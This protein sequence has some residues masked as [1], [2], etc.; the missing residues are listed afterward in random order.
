MTLEEY[1]LLKH[2]IENIKATMLDS[3][4][5]ANTQAVEFHG[6]DVNSFSDAE[7]LRSA[8]NYYVDI[9][10]RAV[11]IPNEPSSY[12]ISIGDI[13]LITINGNGFNRKAVIKLISTLITDQRESGYIT[14]DGTVYPI[15]SI[16]VKSPLGEAILNK[17]VGTTQEY[18]ADYRLFTA[19]IERK[20]SLNDI[21]TKKSPERH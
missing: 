19:T 11:V 12:E 10:S 2:T 5:N 15:Q 18:I 9:L 6:Y 4:R 13:V 14:V 8:L 1:A 3:E 7:L 20:C 21:N 16:T 17:E